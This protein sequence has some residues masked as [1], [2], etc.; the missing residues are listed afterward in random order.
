MPAAL[1]LLGRV[2]VR[3]GS[4]WPARAAPRVAPINQ[5]RLAFTQ[6]IGQIAQGEGATLLALGRSGRLRQYAVASGAALA[7][8]AGLLLPPTSLARLLRNS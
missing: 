6:P 7:P 5:R 8:A 1:A 4:A 2:Q 3:A